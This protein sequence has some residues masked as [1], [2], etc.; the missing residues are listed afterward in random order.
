MPIADSFVASL[1]RIA[2]DELLRAMTEQQSPKG[3]LIWAIGNEVKPADLY[4]YL[5][6]RFGAPNGIQNL[7][8]KDDSDNLI[9]WDWTLACEYG[10]VSFLGMN[11]RT[12]VQLIGPFP[13]NNDDKDS[14]ITQLRDDF[15]KQR[16]KM[17]EI[18]SLL[19][20]WTEFANPYQRLRRAIDLL[21]KELD[22][23]SLD[24]KAQAI[25]DF[26]LHADPTRY[27]QKWEEI[28]M[29]YSRGLGICFGIRSMNPVMA[30][31]FVNLIL[32]ALMK[33]DIRDD[34]R[35][36][37]N[38]FRQHIDIRIKSLHLT[39]DGFVTPIDYANE[40]CRDYH[41]IVNERNDLL[42]GNVSIE[43]LKFNE[44]YFNGRVPVFQEY[45]SMWDR[46][47]GVDVKSVGLDKVANEVAAVRRFIGYVLSCL[48]PTVREEV[49][50]MLDKRDLGH[51]EKSGRWGILFPDHLVDMKF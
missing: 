31:A 50:K 37:E 33:K 5:G 15:P 49:Q 25:P 32:F 21:L 13:F 18:S 38:A 40:A 48:D 2:P 22:A 34:K 45:R 24:P 14:F 19:E 7:L 1:T 29:R 30:E 20:R 4:C 27:K 11:F 43:K 9:H 17:S 16:A 51:N 36:R 6:A 42:H 41:A 12:E 8:R 3:G 28:A 46:S 39:C 47:V 23:L 44:V 35:L 26:H 10:W